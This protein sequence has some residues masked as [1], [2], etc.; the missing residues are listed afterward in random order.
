MHRSLLGIAAI[1]T[2]VGFSAPVL[3]KGSGGG[4]HEHA[5]LTISKKND[6]ASPK[7]MSSKPAG[8]FKPAKNRNDPYKNYNFR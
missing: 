7:M 5:N 8:K 6:T 3:A 4:S 2:C 1:L